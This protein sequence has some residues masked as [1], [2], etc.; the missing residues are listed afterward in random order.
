MV[1]NEQFFIEPTF[2]DIGSAAVLEFT[3][4]DVNLLANAEYNGHVGFYQNQFAIY[5]YMRMN[6]MGDYVIHYPVGNALLVQPH[7]SCAWT[8][9]GDFRMDQKTI[10][11]YRM[12]IN[13]EE[14]YDEWMDS[15]FDRFLEW[16]G[17]AAVGLSTAGV[18]ATNMMTENIMGHS[19]LGVRAVLTGG[20]LFPNPTFAEGVPTKLQDAFVKTASTGTGWMQGLRTMAASNPAKFGHL[21][22]ANINF[23]TQ[24]SADTEQ[25]VGDPVALYDARVAAAPRKLRR[26]LKR[27]G[28]G[29]F[30]SRNLPIWLVA[31]PIADSMYD[32]KLTQDQLTAQNQPRI[33][34]QDFQVPNGRGGTSALTVY[35]IDKT[36]VIPVEEMEVFAEYLQGTPYFEYLTLTGVI[37]LGG[38]FGSIPERGSAEIA[39]RIVRNTNGRNEDLGKTT[40]LAHML[41]ANG[42]NDYEYIS[43]GYQFATPA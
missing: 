27:G 43:G 22:D 25:F 14:C 11:P 5:N 34:T 15:T 28:R 24:V 21:D 29:G 13:V 9:Q 33:S 10:K 6:Q 37:Q 3:V 26:A 4:G 39:M 12:K 19:T 31:A 41:G 38:S 40:Y 1:N 32:A 20:G 16:G 23:A 2:T 35:Y 30:N 42:I 7:N 17:D 8:P 18:R 36:A